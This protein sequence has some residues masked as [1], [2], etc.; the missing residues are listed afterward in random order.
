METPLH[1][2][3]SLLFQPFSLWNN[4][5]LSSEKN[6]VASLPSGQRVCHK[7][8]KQ[9]QPSALQPESLHFFQKHIL[10]PVKFTE[11]NRLVVM[12]DISLAQRQNL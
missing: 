12:T 7:W 1:C 4:P 8:Q 5:D 9:D 6:K 2:V 11:L 10:R 3:S